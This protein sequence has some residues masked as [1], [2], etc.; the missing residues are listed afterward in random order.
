MKRETI[1]AHLATFPGAGASCP[2]GPEALVYKVKD[3]IFAILSQLDEPPRISLKCV[4][5]DGALLTGQ[6]QSVKQVTISIKNTGSPW[7]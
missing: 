4:P 3:K 5:A 7:N 6:F 2:F 1:A